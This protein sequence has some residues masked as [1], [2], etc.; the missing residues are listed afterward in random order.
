[1]AVTYFKA[2]F[3]KSNWETEADLPRKQS[4]Y[5]VQTNIDIQSP[6]TPLIILNYPCPYLFLHSFFLYT[7]LLLSLL[8]RH[9]PYLSTVYYE[10][11]FL[12]FIISYC[13]SLSFV[14]LSDFFLLLLFLFC[15][16]RCV[17]KM[18]DHHKE[19]YSVVINIC[20]KWGG[21]HLCGP[22][23]AA[24]FFPQSNLIMSVT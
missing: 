6:C 23:H 22:V 18:Q 8:L 11:H 17:T 15:F 14:S 2:W 21:G 9:P 12:F 4:G 13:P 24:L 16:L 1:V 5:G 3:C 19:S 7:C 20:N 10:I